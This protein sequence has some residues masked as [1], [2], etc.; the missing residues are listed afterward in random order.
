M[1][2]S[3]NATWQ[4]QRLLHANIGGWDWN[5]IKS[6][7]FDFRFCLMLFLSCHHVLV[8]NVNILFF[9]FF[10]TKTKNTT[11]YLPSSILLMK[12]LMVK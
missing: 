12:K 7:F 4:A 10:Q 9:Y 5:Q 3:E 2:L 11:K 1:E 6:S 8:G